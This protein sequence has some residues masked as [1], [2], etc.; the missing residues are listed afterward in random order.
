MKYCRNC[1]HQIS[2]QAGFCPYCG[3]DTGRETANRQP[4]ANGQ[5][6]PA[7]G[8]P[9]QPSSAGN[10]K[11]ITLPP[12]PVPPAGGTPE[13]RGAGPLLAVIAVL[14]IAVGAAAFFF[15]NRQDGIRASES[16]QSEED[17]S[18]AESE[19]NSREESKK[20]S[21][22]EESRKKNE[23]ESAAKAASVSA[24]VSRQAES[25]A[26]KQ[27][28]VEAASLEAAKAASEAEAA[29]AA[30]LA[31]AASARN[32]GAHAAAGS[33]ADELDVIRQVYEATQRGSY[34][35][36]GGRWYRGPVLV[37][38]VAG[39]GSSSV[40]DGAMKKAGYT[41]YSLEYYYMNPDVA[42][43]LNGYSGLVF[44][45]AVIDGREYR[46]YFDGYEHLIRR[47]GPDGTQ[48]YPEINWFI[49]DIYDA[50]AAIH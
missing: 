45:Y 25:V 13:K 7:G 31:A 44:V 14:V 43:D 32:R 41:S 2:D 28:Q 26:Q 49:R 35:Q 19:E 3:A 50:G 46:Y 24:E 11:R 18:A 29:S 39:R 16:L 42:S 4:A 40:I 17:A 36:N 47:I 30:S 20:E 33:L 34:T 9:K 1:G 8:R 22:R 15:K 48:D 37:K 27:S 21:S 6:Q 5:N 10:Q 12:A 38:A 23:S